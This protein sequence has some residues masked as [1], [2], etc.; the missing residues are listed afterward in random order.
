[1]FLQS[2]QFSLS[3]TLPTILMLLLGIILRR[4]RMLDDHF[5]QVASKLV[6]NIALP[7]LLFIN[8]V[9]QPADYSSQ[10]WLV[11]AGFV[12]TFIIYFAS[13]WLALRYI[14]DK[15][16]RGIFVQGIF[17]GNS[18]ILGLALCINAYG[19]MATAPAS[20]Y[21]ACITLLFNVLAVITLTNSLSVGKVSLPRMAKSLMTNPLI[22]GIVL[23]L[24]VSKFDIPLPSSIL[25]TG[26]YLANIAL[27]IALICAGASL[28]FKQLKQFKN[29][30]ESQTQVNSIVWWASFGRLIVSPLLTIFIGKFILDLDPM[31]LGILFLM[32]STPVAAASYAMV[33]NFGG[34][35][36]ATANIIAVTMLGYMFTSSIGIFILKQLQWI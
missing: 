29:S 22:I 13:E 17:R 16:Y 26:D 10:I 32:S 28:D 12:S 4:R 2:L 15:S 11:G 8:I 34:D 18:G 30:Q 5:C 20:V 19:A 6:F 21:T 24:I 9:K 36:T 35:A 25:R 14:R 1:M 3:V 31:S 27:P 33:R 7:S 23:G